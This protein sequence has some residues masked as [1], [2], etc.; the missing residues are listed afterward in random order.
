MARRGQREG[1]AEATSAA[2]GRE[3]R[4]AECAGQGPRSGQRRPGR[5]TGSGHVPPDCTA[6]GA[7]E[8]LEDPAAP[9]RPQ[10]RRA[11][12]ATCASCASRAASALREREVALPGV[13][14]SPEA[15]AGRTRIPWE[16]G[17]F[18]K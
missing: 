6:P 7:A 10:P 14:G 17:D 12:L 8:E 11:A 15:G 3:E 2:A 16:E 1:K 18:Y 5:E 4:R 13:R 9:L